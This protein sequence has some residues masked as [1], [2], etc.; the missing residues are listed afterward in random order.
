MTH[1]TWLQVIILG[2]VEGL[3]EFLPISSTGHLI[4]AEEILH[5]E[6]PPGRVFDIVIQLGAI[7]AVVWEYRRRIADTLAGVAAIPWLRSQCVGGMPL[8]DEARRFLPQA[9]PWVAGFAV[10]FA[11]CLADPW[12]RVILPAVFPFYVT[13]A[14]T[15]S[16]G[17][18]NAA[19]VAEVAT[20]GDMRIE[21]HGLGAY[22]AA[23][24][25]AGDFHRVVLGVA[26]MSVFVVVIN[27]L[28]WRPLY[29]YAERKF[30]FR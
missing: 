29:Y 26:T 7:L 4:L 16:G 6:G 9:A 24:T 5:F 21:A 28:F 10:L 14:I 3:T 22:I 1:D 25:A 15:A 20:W 17:S 2:I 30:T 19:I 12:R 13:G 27:R 8:E 18:W 11:A 23:A